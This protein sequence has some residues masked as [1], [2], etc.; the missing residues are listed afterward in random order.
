M[1]ADVSAVGLAIRLRASITFPMGISLTSYGAT[2]DTSHSPSVDRL[3]L[4][5]A[6]N[7]EFGDQHF[8]EYGK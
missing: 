1:V 7:N 4:S 6:E 8:T 2:R 5:S 3:D